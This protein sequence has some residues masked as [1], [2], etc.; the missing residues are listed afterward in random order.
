M[1]SFMWGL[2]IEKR[3]KF[4]GTNFTEIAKTEKNARKKIRLL[5]L[6]HAAEGASFIDISSMLNVHYQTVRLW[7]KNFLNDGLDGLNEK[8]GRGLKSLLSKEQE[9]ELLKAIDVGYNDLNGGRLFG[10]D[11]QKMIDKNFGI[12]CSLSTVYNILHRA[13]LVW[14][15]ARSKSPKADLAA[16]EDFKKKFLKTSVQSSLK[17]FP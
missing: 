17:A 3:L 16:Q 14:I 11:I 1:G 5:A 8:E 2:N 6:S 15:T 7:V 12:K 4:R 10:H 13:G 9:S